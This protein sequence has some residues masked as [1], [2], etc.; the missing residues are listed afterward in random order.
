MS[1]VKRKTQQKKTGKKNKDDKKNKD[2]PVVIVILF[3][4]NIRIQVLLRF[5]SWVQMCNNI[6]GKSLSTPSIVRPEVS[7]QFILYYNIVIQDDSPNM[8]TPPIFPLNN[9]FIQILIFGIL[10]I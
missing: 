8:L 7:L 2:H 10:K 9:E 3:K 1:F 4:H 5:L 6:V